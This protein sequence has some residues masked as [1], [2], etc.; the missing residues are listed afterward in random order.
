MKKK[1]KKNY[2]FLNS[3]ANL[4]QSIQVLDSFLNKAA[5]V[6]DGEL[7]SDGS[8]ENPWRLGSIQHIEELKCLIRIVPIWISGIICFLAMAQQ[9][10]FTLSQALKMDRH[11]GPHFR[12]PAGSLAVI[13]M[14]ALTAF[15]PVYDRLLVPAARR[16]TKQPSGIT[17]LQRMGIGIAVASLSMVVAG[18]VEEKRRRS[19]ISHGGKLGIAPIS[20]L[21]LAPQLALMGVAEAFNAI[22]QIEFYYKQFPEHMRS[23]AGALLFCTLAG[24][25]Y[26]STLVVSVVHS[27]TR[28]NGADWLD[29]NINRGKLDYF[30][31]IIAG[32]GGLNLLYFLVCS[33]FYRYKGSPDQEEITTEEGRMIELNTSKLPTDA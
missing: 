3:L 29:N 33:H 31:Y 7:K 19:A 6:T 17:L 20:V 11:L 32:M 8:P 10:T 15:I 30:Y 5:I 2:Y 1:K 28:R 9:S 25:S 27:S 21:W 26:L 24:A 22:G 16:L 18:L 12:I 14:L 13:N 23:F 4:T